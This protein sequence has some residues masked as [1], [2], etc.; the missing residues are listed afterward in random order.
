MMPGKDREQTKL[1][2]AWTPPP[3]PWVEG[4]REASEI[5]LGYGPAPRWGV[6]RVSVVAQGFVETLR[7]AIR[8]PFN[9]SQ[10]KVCQ[11]VVETGE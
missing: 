1:E 11:E 3:P 8:A 7:P 6:L 2:R 5:L 9:Q 4:W 10:G